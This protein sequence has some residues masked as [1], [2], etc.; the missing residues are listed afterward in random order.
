MP[1]T[2][3]LTTLLF[4]DDTKESKQE[5]DMKRA[6]LQAL[7]ELADLHER[8]KNIFIWR[9]PASSK[10]YG[11]ALFFCCVLTL[12]LPAQYIAKLIYF[13]GGV[14]F[15]HIVPILGAL[16][17]EDR[18]R[19][20]PAFDDVPT[21]A[22]FA[23]EVISQRIAAGLDVN[24]SKR[25]NRNTGERI[26]TSMSAPSTPGGS[27]N[28][29][30]QD[31]DWKK[32]GERAAIGKAWVTERKIGKDSATASR[33]SDTPQPSAA[34]HTFPCQHTTAPGL[35]TLTETEILFTPM[36]ST[37]PKL[38]IPF[39]DLR[40]VKK[41]GLLK[42]LTIKWMSLESGEG[43]IQQEVFLWVGG[44]DEIFARLIG[45]D[46]KRWMKA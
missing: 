33:I 42:G 10:I 7:N 31:I 13:L 44:R 14:F 15:W 29:K 22:D 12:V 24:P 40:G 30:G 16:P 19:L 4:L 21:D 27:K 39:T 37:K 1:Q 46:V 41:T 25:N 32:W 5:M 36:T 6:T 9:R 28:D 11:S 26:N 23:M 45:T 20:P 3:T 35:L 43:E 18:A 38:S 34:T 8:I 2:P 17:S